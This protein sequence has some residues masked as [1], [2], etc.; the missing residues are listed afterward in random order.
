MTVI[1][2]LFVSILFISLLCIVASADGNN[3]NPTAHFSA[4]VTS[5][6][7]PLDVQF[8]DSS[9]NA[10][11][12]SWN[13]EDGNGSILQNPE[14]IYSTLGDYNVNLT[15]A[16]ESNATNSTFV[17]IHAL[18][19]VV[20]TAPVAAFTTNSSSGVSPLTVQ[21]TNTSAGTP[22]TLNWSF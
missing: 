10:T 16:N 12:W 4:N 6:Y 9:I 1:K 22:T 19:P 20:Q 2:R 14:H 17:M 3:T 13:F 11:S 7:V 15:V 21:F 18:A 8:N 5:G